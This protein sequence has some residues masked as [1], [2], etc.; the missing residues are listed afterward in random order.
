MRYYGTRFVSNNKNNNTVSLEN[1]TFLMLNNLSK[2]IS[3]KGR[4]LV[5]GS[6]YFAENT[7]LYPFYPYFVDNSIFVLNILSWLYGGVLAQKLIPYYTSTETIPTTLIVNI[8]NTQITTVSQICYV[9]I[10]QTSNNTLFGINIFFLTL[11]GTLIVVPLVFI[12]L[13]RKK[14]KIF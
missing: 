3:N 10:S 8:T 14:K 11:T 7:M 9:C 1:G 5:S 2:S 13:K 12:I 6:G 4:I